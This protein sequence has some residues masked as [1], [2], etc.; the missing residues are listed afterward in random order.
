MM[1]LIYLINNYKNNYN[2]NKINKLIKNNN[3]SNNNKII[4]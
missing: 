2:Y 3:K 4:K 1:I